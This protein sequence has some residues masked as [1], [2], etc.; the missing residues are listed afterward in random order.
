MPLQLAITAALLIVPASTFAE[1][2]PVL[3]VWT[4]P[5]SGKLPYVIFNSVNVRG[6]EIRWNGV[7]ISQQALA[8]YV[9][10]S[11]ALNPIPT[12]L[13]DPDH[14]DC[15]FDK[16]IRRLLDRSFPCRFGA[17][18]QGSPQAFKKAPWKRT[19]GAPA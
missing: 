6:R 13:F 15:S 7:R 1:C 10:Q 14:K 5:S 3:P 18:F 12:L 8:S 9:R 4:E 19:R 2:V 16:R 17:C 11:A